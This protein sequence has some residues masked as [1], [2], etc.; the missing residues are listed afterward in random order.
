MMLLL[1]EL[2]PPPPPL[3]LPSCGSADV[4]STTEPVVKVL[5]LVPVLVSSRDRPSLVVVMTTVNCVVDVPRRG[6]VVVLGVGVLLVEGASSVGVLVG[7]VW[8]EVR[9][10]VS[11]LLGVG[12]AV[13]VGSGALVVGS[14]AGV[15]GGGVETDVSEGVDV[16]A[17]GVELG[18]DDEL[19]V[20][21][22]WRF[23]PWCR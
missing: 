18:A 17:G 15:E 13:G 2:R 4:V 10:V 3:E 5:V 19:P 8:S 16:S 20:P 9:E 21:E 11:W 12:L 6:L 23:S 14:S 22:A 7:V 1:L